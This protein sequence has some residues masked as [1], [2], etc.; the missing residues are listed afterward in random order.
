MGAGRDPAPG[1]VNVDLA[2]WPGNQVAADV[3]AL[4]FRDSVAVELNMS[5]VIEH[6]HAPLPVMAELW[7][8]A[9]PGAELQIRVPYGSSDIAW[10]DPTHFRPFFAES[11]GVFAQPYHWRMEANYTADWQPTT[12][13]LLLNRENAGCTLV[14]AEDRVKHERNV[15]REM[16]VDLECVKPARPA[17]KGTDVPAEL[18]F[19]LEGD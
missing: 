17:V 5:H 2:W 15:V 18:S 1:W 13:V 4:P 7:R 8:V 12:I 10:T 19:E 14:E 9:A 16:I 6:I 3:H 11:W